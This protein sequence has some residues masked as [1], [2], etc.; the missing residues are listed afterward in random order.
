MTR[1]FFTLGALIALLGVALGAFGA[2]GL[3][4]HFDANPDLAGNYDTAAQYQLYHAFGLLI[5]AWAA[6]R[7]PSAWYVRW[8]GW[9]F[10]AGIA[11]FSG[12]LYALSLGGPRLL[13]AVAPFGGTAFIAGWGLLAWTAWRGAA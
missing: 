7:W 1:T 12:S 3:S 2:H 11:L 4:A 13:G 5:A 6:E 10:V 9:L 8:A